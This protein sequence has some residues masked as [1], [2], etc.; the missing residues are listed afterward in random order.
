[1]LTNKLANPYWVLQAVMWSS[2]DVKV[3]NAEVFHQEVVTACGRVC[4]KL[5]Q[6]GNMRSASPRESLVQPL[7]VA[8]DGT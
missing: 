1:M 5:E 6:T 3:G 4:D 8:G 7:D 2:S